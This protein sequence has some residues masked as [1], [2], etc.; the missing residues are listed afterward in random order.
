MLQNSM[1]LSMFFYFSYFFVHSSPDFNVGLVF[2]EDEFEP[3]GARAIPAY[4][5]TA[6]SGAFRQGLRQRDLHVAG[7]GRTPS[8]GKETK[9]IWK[10]C[11]KKNIFRVFER[12]GAMISVASLLLAHVETKSFTNRL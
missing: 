5:Y 1:V 7:L 4:P 10:R 2:L 6:Y 8:T 12:K 11:F 3:V 9:G